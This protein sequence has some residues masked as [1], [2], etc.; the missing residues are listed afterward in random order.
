MKCFDEHMKNTDMKDIWVYANT[1]EFVNDLSKNLVWNIRPMPEQ[2]FCENLVKKK[3]NICPSGA[4][5][6]P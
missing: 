1:T 3:K 2:I 6:I 4:K 5:Q